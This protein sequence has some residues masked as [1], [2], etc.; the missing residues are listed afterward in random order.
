MCFWKLETEPEAAQW[1]IPSIH[2]HCLYFDAYRSCLI[3]Y[4]DLDPVPSMTEDIKYDDPAGTAVR[5]AGLGIVLGA[6][7][8]YAI[9]VCPA[10]PQLPLYFAILAQFHLLEFWTT[11]KYNPGK[12]N[13]KCVSHLA[14]A[15]LSF[16][17]IIKWTRILGRSVR[18]SRGV[19]SRTQILARREA[20]GDDSYRLNYRIPA[21]G[22]RPSRAINGDDHCSPKFLPCFSLFQEGGSRSCYRWHLC[23]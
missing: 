20:S 7:L 23:V 15:D 19:S 4:H 11:A 12:V 16:P 10:N 1:S 17:S 3:Q 9:L 22:N 14:L 8:C 2:E 13:N 6:S 5:A 21:C 18:W